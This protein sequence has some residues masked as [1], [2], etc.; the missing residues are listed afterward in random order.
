MVV[1]LTDSLN[2]TGKYSMIVEF[3]CQTNSS[4]SLPWNPYLKPAW[5]A[6]ISRLGLVQIN[7]YHALFVPNFT[8][9]SAKHQ[10]RRLETA[11]QTLVEL[12][13]QNVLS[14]QLKTMNGLQNVSWFCS[15]F[16]NMSLSLQLQFSNPLEVSSYN[17]DKLIVK[18]TEPNL[19]I[20]SNKH[21]YLF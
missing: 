12:I 16:T 6:G 10:K 1:K 3:T 2:H 9:P 7:F 5:I 20:L 11:N 8:V 18:F 17:V 21:D 14:V 13:N 4:K 15:N 19:F